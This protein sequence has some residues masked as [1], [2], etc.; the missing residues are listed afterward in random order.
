MSRVSG[1]LLIKLVSL[2]PSRVTYMEGTRC[3]ETGASFSLLL[4]D[5]SAVSAVLSLHDVICRPT[6]RVSQRYDTHCTN[7]HMPDMK[8]SH[9]HVSVRCRPRPCDQM[10]M[11]CWVRLLYIA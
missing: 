9:Y 10:A 5:F 11:T 4:Q 2:R 6:P 1:A 8:L 3:L 7:G